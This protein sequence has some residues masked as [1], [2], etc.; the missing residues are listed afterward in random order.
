M[1]EE[2]LVEGEMCVLLKAATG[3]LAADGDELAMIEFVFV[4]ECLME[5]SM[6]N[7]FIPCVSHDG[8]ILGPTMLICEQKIG[9]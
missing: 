9:D 4:W 7:I 1:A 6:T 8:G 5:V 2:V 3:M